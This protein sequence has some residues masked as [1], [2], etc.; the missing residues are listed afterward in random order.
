MKLGGGN[1]HI[2]TGADIRSTKTQSE[3]HCMH[4]NYQAKYYAQDNGNQY[5]ILGRLICLP[6]CDKT[7][8]NESGNL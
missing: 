8:E 6:D 1:V 2:G 7:S 3:N 4:F 5:S